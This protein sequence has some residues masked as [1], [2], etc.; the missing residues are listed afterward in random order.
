[1]PWVGSSCRGIG[2]PARRSRT[3]SN[4][5]FLAV[6]WLSPAR[7]FAVLVTTNEGLDSANAA[8]EVAA[9]IITKVIK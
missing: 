6:A 2:L 1:M 5:F 4:T 8:D 9:N 3:R 7:D